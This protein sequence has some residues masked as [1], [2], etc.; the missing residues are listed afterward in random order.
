MLACVLNH[1][2]LSLTVSA[3]L[4]TKTDQHRCSYYFLTSTKGRRLCF[5]LSLSVCLSVYPLDYTK[6][7]ERIL[8]KFFAVVGRGRRNNRLDFGGD[9]GHD[10]DPEIC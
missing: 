6:G 3:T 1:W 7:Y 5:Y 2:F 10:P 9:P 4:F 8:M